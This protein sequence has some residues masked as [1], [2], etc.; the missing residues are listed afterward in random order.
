MLAPTPAYAQGRGKGGEVARAQSLFKKADDAYNAKRYAEALELFKQSYATVAS[1]N[2][3]LYIA[4]CMAQLGDSRAAY[5]EFQKVFD[6]ADARATSEPKYAPTRDSARLERDEVGN[7]LAIVTINVA[8]ADAST[9]VRVS[10]T[11][12]PQSDWG[13]PQPFTPGNV[14]VV[15]V[16]AGKAPITQNIALVAGDKRDLPLDAAP[17]AAAVATE[18]PVVESGPKGK[19]NKPLLIAGIVAGGVG[20][21]G[22]V[23]FAIEGSS[24][25]SDFSTLQK[26]CPNNN[27]TQGTTDADAKSSGKSAQTVANIGLITG[28]VGL[29]AGATL[30]TLAFVKRGPA[31]APTT[32]SANLVL[33]PGYAGLAGTF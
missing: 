22:M 14:D 15:V 32:G 23:L 3:H 16:S 11:D 12:V 18:A 26:D 24:A 21:V 33:K 27:C 29:A 10:G 28:A 1:P 7:K 20:V 4:R 2:S 30:V 9:T 31:A 25:S 8:H 17:P 6:E 19:P 5:V 13:K